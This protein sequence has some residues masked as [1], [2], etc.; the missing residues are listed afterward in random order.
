VP[1][2]W[3]VADRPVARRHRG[4]GGSA[5]RALIARTCSSSPYAASFNRFAPKLFVSIS[6]APAA[7]YAR[8]TSFTSSG[9]LRQ[10]SS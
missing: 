6:S 4:G 1:T 7:T 3:R 5:A 10:S 2:G 9:S 8:C